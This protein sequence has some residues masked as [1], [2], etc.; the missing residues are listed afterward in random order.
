MKSSEAAIISMR[1]NGSLKH[2][3]GRQAGRTYASASLRVTNRLTPS[4]AGTATLFV[5]QA[6]FIQKDSLP[7]GCSAPEKNSSRLCNLPPLERYAG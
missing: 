3:A 5:V 1:R 7:T 4:R 6:R 2:N